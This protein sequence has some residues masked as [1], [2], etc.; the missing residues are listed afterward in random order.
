MES[1]LIV[2][3]DQS[4]FELYISL[5]R[6]CFAHASVTC[7]LNGVE[8]LK[9]IEE[10]DYSIILSDIEMPQMDGIEF[11]R[12]LKKKFPALALK[13]AFITSN[14][15]PSHISYFEKEGIPYLKKP[16]AKRDFIRIV[17]VISQKDHPLSRGYTVPSTRK[18]KRFDF[19]ADGMILSS[20]IKEEEFIRGEIIN[21]SEGGFAF[22]FKS[23]KLS[24]KQKVK[25]SVEALNIEN[26]EAETVWTKEDSAI[27]TAGFKWLEHGE[28]PLPFH[29][30]KD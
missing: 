4:L 9:T 23:G 18:H 17:K 19:R 30:R 7:V 8:A 27:I 6:K 29:H 25:V 12:A 15:S 26:R 10:K 14:C 13:T 3:D 28:T 22:L 21:I 16:F 11:H 20:R 1:I 24:R 2:D 5:V